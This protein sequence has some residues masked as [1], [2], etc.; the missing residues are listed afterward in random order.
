[1]P[2]L[3]IEKLHKSFGGIKILE[4]INLS[5]KD[6]EF[7]SLLGPSGCG[8]STLLR[9]I[10]GL[11][12]ADRGDIFLKKE[13]I[14]N[15]EPQKR[16][17]GMVFQNYCLFPHLNAYENLAFPLRESGLSK[18]KIASIIAHNFDLV[19][20]S[21]N[22]LKFPRELSG[23]QQQR[24]A[25]ARAL[26]LKPKIL[27]LDEP[28]SALDA[29]VRN[30]LRSDIKAL[31]KELNISIIMVTHD[32]EE[33]ISMSDKIALMHEGKIVETSE[34]RELYTRPK[35]YF[36]AHFIGAINV[37]RSK[38]K[39]HCLR[40]ENLHIQKGRGENNARIKDIEFLGHFLKITLFCEDKKHSDELTANISTKEFNKLNLRLNDRVH[41]HFNEKDLLCYKGKDLLEYAYED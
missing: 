35:H 29:K 14:T 10:V 25:I 5:L 36:S 17:F 21:G 23:G 2:L 33:A 9:I 22:E 34:P 32:Q 11:E 38:N 3:R 30:K 20:L 15:L 8:K 12:G 13:K 39:Y 31:Q 19:G 18:E 1:M 6:G 16:K 24:V 26:S 41:Y 37:L 4:D 27:L 7:L 28:L 40:P